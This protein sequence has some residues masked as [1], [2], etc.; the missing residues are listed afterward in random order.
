MKKRCLED[1]NL[2]R[3]DHVCSWLPTEDNDKYFPLK[4]VV[5]ITVG[6]IGY[7]KTDWKLSKEDI[8][9]RN[10]V[11]GID[12]EDRIIAEGYAMQSKERFNPS[13]ISNKNRW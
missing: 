8:I 6:E 7:H 13:R 5:I 9:E 4:E 1:T 10:L 3:G 12:E 2:V 11:Q